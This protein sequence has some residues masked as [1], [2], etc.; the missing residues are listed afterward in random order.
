LFVRCKTCDYLLW[1]IP[2]GPCPECG[3]PFKPTDYD[4]V[5]ASVQFCCPKCNQDYYGTTM[6]GHLQPSR[7]VCA[8]CS[9][10]IESD[11]MILRPTAGLREDVSTIAPLAWVDPSRRGFFGRFFA[12]IRDAIGTPTNCMQRVHAGSPSRHAYRFA[13][14]AVT[15]FLIC[16]VVPIFLMFGVI[17]PIAASFGLGGGGIAYT[18][19]AVVLG[20]VLM[21]VGVVIALLTWTA[22]AHLILRLTGG[23]PHPMSRT[24][25]AICYSAGTGF[26]VGVPCLGFYMTPIAGVWWCAAA[27]V[28]L[29]K[30]QA[31]SGWRAALAVL[32]LPALVIGASIGMAA[33]GI[34]SVHSAFIPVAQAPPFAENFRLAS[35]AAKASSTTIVPTGSVYA[36]GPVMLAS[37]RAAS[38]SALDIDPTIRFAELIR[39]GVLKP[40]A[41]LAPGSNSTTQ[42]AT[43]AGLSLDEL[44]NLSVELHAPLLREH[45]DSG[46]PFRIGD[47]II[48][49][50]VGRYDFVAP[51]KFSP[52]HIIVWPEAWNTTPAKQTVHVLRHDGSVDAIEAARFDDELAAENA[53]RIT[54]GMDNMLGR[55]AL[56]S[57]SEVKSI[58]APDDSVP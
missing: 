28:M 11:Q 31:V 3:T 57:P 19:V 6:Q 23:T 56:P 44:T 1:N 48:D 55:L 35:T 25:H 17:M 16:S 7:F 37:L 22:S 49:P 40:A 14:L 58:P 46:D 27:A 18:I 32:A 30:A 50:K 36:D 21:S 29:V 51:P 47:L 39:R 38:A 43:F 13:V 53:R 20:V 45:A 9:A 4:F 41:V 54:S 10:E 42:S 15:L 2:P 34:Y 5:P 12:T 52:W 24:A 33:W 26:L 8:R